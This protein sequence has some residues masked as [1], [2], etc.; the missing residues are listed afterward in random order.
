MKRATFL[1]E[2]MNPC[3]TNYIQ[4][5]RF[6]FLLVT[7]SIIFNNKYTEGYI[8]CYSIKPEKVHEWKF[9]RTRNALGTHFLPSIPFFPE[10]SESTKDY[11]AKIIYTG[12]RRVNSLKRFALQSSHHY[13]EYLTTSVLPFISWLGI[14]R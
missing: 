5:M 2:L 6:D 4:V 13:Y 7:A 11:F 1:K 3:W 14:H 8:L 9:K 10:D 12:G